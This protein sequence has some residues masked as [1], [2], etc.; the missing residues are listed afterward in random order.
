MLKVVSGQEAGRRA[1]LRGS[2]WSGLTKVLRQCQ[3]KG[4]VGVGQC[5]PLRTKEMMQPCPLSL[6]AISLVG[7]L[8]PG[9]SGS[10]QDAIDDRLN[11]ARAAPAVLS[12]EQLQL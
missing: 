8:G 6:H 2:F 11:L 4:W 12:L 1:T 5:G 7:Q 9:W 10:S 3:V